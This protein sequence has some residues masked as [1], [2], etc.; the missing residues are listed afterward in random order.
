MVIGILLC[1]TCAPFK[2]NKST[3]II[4]AIIPNITCI[5][6]IPKVTLYLI[7]N[8]TNGLITVK[9]TLVVSLGG[10]GL[11]NKHTLNKKPSKEGIKKGVGNE[12]Y[13]YNILFFYFLVM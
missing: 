5:V 7:S 11:L 8:M 1:L 12:K 9:V 4:S 10:E 2:S 6:Q 3:A 13:N